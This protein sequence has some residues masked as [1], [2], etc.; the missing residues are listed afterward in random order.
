MFFKFLF[1]T[2]YKD[3]P[4]KKY[5]IVQAGPNTQLG[6][7][8]NGLLSLAYQVN[9]ENIVVALP[10]NATKKQRT[11]ETISFDIFTTSSIPQKTSIVKKMSKLCQAIP[12]ISY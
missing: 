3:T 6:G 1:Q 5:K 7:L 8:K 11:M 2:K 9:T 12:Q 10:A 4:I